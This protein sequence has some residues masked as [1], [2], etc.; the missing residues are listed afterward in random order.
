MP[1]FPVSLNVAPLKFTFRELTGG[2]DHREYDG[3]LVA[4][5]AWAVLFA[6]EKSWRA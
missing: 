2:G 4:K 5:G 3:N 1:A 6:L